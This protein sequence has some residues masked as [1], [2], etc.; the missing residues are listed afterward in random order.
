[1]NTHEIL[2]ALEAER[3]RLDKAISALQRTTPARR[4]R[5]MSAEGRKRISEATK[6]RW[7]AW[8]KKNKKTA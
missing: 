4:A 8:R 7:A 2:A 1:M 6:K 5:R 3:D